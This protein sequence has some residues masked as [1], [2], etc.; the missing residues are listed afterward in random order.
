MQNFDCGFSSSV[1]SSFVCT[2]FLCLIFSVCQALCVKAGV[3]VK[4]LVC[5]R[6][7]CVTMLCERVCVCACMT[8]CVRVCG[9][10]SSTTEVKFRL[11]FVSLCGLELLRV[12]GFYVN[13]AVCQSLCV[14]ADVCAKTLVC[15]RRRCATMFVRERVSECVYDCPCPCVQRLFVNDLVCMN[16]CL[17]LSWFLSI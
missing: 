11:R 14:K 5:E 4:A 9:V 12:Q 13:F 7:R 6:R 2:G 10:C 3:F 15:K 17:C 16:V 1:V 8:L